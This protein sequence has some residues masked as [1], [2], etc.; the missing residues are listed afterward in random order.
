[1]QKQ[2][3][4]P[5]KYTKNTPATQ[6]PASP[7]SSKFL[8]NNGNFPVNTGY[9]NFK[10]MCVWQVSPCR[11]FWMPAAPPFRGAAHIRK[12]PFLPAYISS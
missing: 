10:D 3:I 5:E 9:K 7:I 11:A 8:F 4:L 12:M 1:M 6:R 2:C